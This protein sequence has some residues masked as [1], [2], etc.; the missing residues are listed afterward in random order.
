VGAVE[1]PRPLADPQHVRRAVVPLAGEGVLAGESFLVA[2]DE[3]LVAGGDVGGVQL[4]GGLGVDAAGG[5]EPKSAV[6]AVGH[7]LVASPL[8]AGG[9]ELLVPGVHTGEVGETALG[10]GAKEVQR[11][12][13]LVVRSDQALGVGVAGRAGEQDVVH[14]VAAERRQLDALD[15]L[16]VARPWFGELAGDA[17]HLHQGHP[18]G[19]REDHGHLEDDLELV[20][21]GI[22]GEGV[23][24]LG[25]VARLE[26]ERFSGGHPAELGG[27]LPRL[28]REDERGEGRKRLDH[29]VERPT[30]GPLGLLG[31]RELLP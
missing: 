12:G 6:D 31:G 10:E 15:G 8:G 1:L 7:L 26:Q 13:R 3:G 22:R 20:A 5:H 19:V 16:G 18:R 24:G 27:E 2:Q 11:R 30:V 17:A 14:H 4:G 28:T 21:D 23:E 25:A 9:H 29:G